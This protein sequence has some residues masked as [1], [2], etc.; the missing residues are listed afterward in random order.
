LPPSRFLTTEFNPVSKKNGTKHPPFDA[1]PNFFEDLTLRK[2]ATHL[3]PLNFAIKSPIL[4]GGTVRN[5]GFWDPPAGAVSDFEPSSLILVKK[6]E[7]IGINVECTDQFLLTR[8]GG[9]WV[10]QQSQSAARVD[11]IVIKE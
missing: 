7:N 3:F 1:A 5:I 4:T 10:V 8:S 2:V 11:G 9:R 6:S